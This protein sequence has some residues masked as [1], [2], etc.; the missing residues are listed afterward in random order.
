MLAF[1]RRQEL[2]PEPIDIPALVRGMTDLL[3]RSLGPSN[4]IE[5]RFPL[6]L[7]L[8][9][10]DV[11]QLEMALLNL[12]V[13]ARDAMPDGGLI[14]IAAREEDIVPDQAIGLKPGRYVC[15]SVVDT[16]EGMD[17]ATL[18][19]AMEPFFTT[20]GVGK[21]TGLGLSMIHGL[22]EQLGGRFI[23]K[24]KKGEGTTA[25]LWL[26]AAAA[27]SAAVFHDA[28]PAESK[29]AAMDAPLVVLTVDDDSLVLMN[30]IAMLEDLGHKALGATSGAE[31]LEILRRERKVDL[32]IS[33]QAMPHM[34]GSQLV[35]IVK[36]DRPSLPVI[37][38]TGY[39]ELPPE[40]DIGVSKLTKPFRQEELVR[41][42][43]DVMEPKKKVRVG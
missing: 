32:L 25:E 27:G 10:A 23:L 2:S 16:G 4:K 15:L 20:K 6:A 7:G 42:L 9:L 19:R 8:V 41:V 18:E 39:A 40:A 1:A 35:E 28:Q 11:N 21:G 34:T 30:T 26:P 12:A 14:I 13:N 33:D 5:I 3:Q 22:T 37:L 38:A 43:V 29:S 17:E 36:A 24:S 31:A